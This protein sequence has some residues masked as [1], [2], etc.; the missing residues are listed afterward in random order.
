MA[1]HPVGLVGVLRSAVTVGW[2]MEFRMLGLL[3]VVDDGRPVTIGPGK[4][5]ALLALLLLNANQ[6]LS[7]DRLIDELW[8]ERQRPENAA[9]TVQI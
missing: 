7:T 2:V 3:E 5:S 6:P 8:D 9:K 4:E 1:M